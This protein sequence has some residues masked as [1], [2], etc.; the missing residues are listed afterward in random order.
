MPKN[1]SAKTDVENASGGTKV[2]DVKVPEPVKP[3]SGS[4][5]G[6]DAKPS[7]GSASGYDAKPSSGSASGY[8][9]K[10]SSG[11]ASGNDVKPSTKP[12]DGVTSDSS[13]D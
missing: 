10:P 1:T 2:E 9:A 6:Y 5:S 11:S 7:S 12:A 3:S 4:A 13:V 8:D